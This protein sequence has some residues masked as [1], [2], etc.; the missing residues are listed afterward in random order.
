MLELREDPGALLICRRKGEG[1]THLE[2]ML[3]GD[4]VRGPGPAR[5]P[6]RCTHALGPPLRELRGQNPT[7]FGTYYSCVF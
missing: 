7:E 5:S 1:W 4:G 3:R 2:R 6:L